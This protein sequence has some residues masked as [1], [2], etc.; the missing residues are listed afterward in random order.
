LLQIDACGAGGA[1]PAPE[2]LARML[3]PHVADW[4]RRRTR[5]SIAN[6]AAMPRGHPMTKTRLLFPILAATFL[7]GVVHAGEFSL[8]GAR[9]LAENSAQASVDVTVTFTDRGRSQHETSEGGEAAKTHNA[10]SVR[11]ADVATPDTSDDHHAASEAPAPKPAD[12]TSDAPHGVSILPPTSIK[13]PSY[14]WQSLVP[15]TIK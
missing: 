1:W 3:L 9:L 8:G 6:P 4:S 14:R 5:A 12:T 15:G 2:A 10:R 13:R 11:G 7:G